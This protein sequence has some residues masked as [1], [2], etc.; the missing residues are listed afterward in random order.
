M[1]ISRYEEEVIRHYNTHLLTYMSDFDKII[2]MNNNDQ[3][4]LFI[5]GFQTMLHVLSI[6]Y[7]IKMTEEQI[8]SYLEKCPLLFLEYTEQVYLKQSD[9]IHTPSMFVY[10]VLLGNISLGKNKCVNNSFMK[11]LYKCSMLLHF[12]DNKDITIDNRKQ[13]VNE[14][15]KP[16]LL[17]FT[18]KDFFPV[19][20][21]F[22]H[23]QTKLMLYSNSVAKFFL[24]LSSFLNFFK[25][26]KKYYTNDMVKEI[27]YTKFM[28]QREVFEEH[29]NNVSTITQMNSIIKWIFSP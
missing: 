12:L 20:S 26:T 15:Q 3:S 27:Y 1:S 6:I 29:L 2:M 17:C 24:L 25:N 16:Y 22:E 14:F 7:C 11:H 13:I 8:N 10:N 23:I 18:K 9:I 19:L 21:V 4:K 5:Q 28:V